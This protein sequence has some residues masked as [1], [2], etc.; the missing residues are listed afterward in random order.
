[1]P[2]IILPAGQSVRIGSITV[3]AEAA[4]VSDPTQGGRELLGYLNRTEEAAAKHM[5]E[6]INRASDR[7]VQQ[8][9]V[10]VSGTGPSYA[11]VT[12]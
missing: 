8:F 4:P 10:H 11:E 12:G 6:A 2:E 3:R 9:A 5:E 1:M 7:M